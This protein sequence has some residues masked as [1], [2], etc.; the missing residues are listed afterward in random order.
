M[1]GAT[2]GPTGSWW[3][4]KDAPGRYEIHCSCERWKFAGTAAEIHAASRN[5]DDSPRQGHIVTI[6]HGGRRTDLEEMI[7]PTGKVLPPVSPKP[8]DGGFA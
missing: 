1:S 6:M 3:P 5:H 4:A 2:A 8:W 7:E